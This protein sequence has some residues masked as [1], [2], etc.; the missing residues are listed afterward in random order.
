MF[1]F[2]ALVFAGTFV[3]LGVGSGSAGIGDLL[4]GN[5]DF[6]SQGGGSPSVAKARRKAEANPQDPQAQRAYA[7][8]LQA[9]G[10][11]EEAIPALRRY[12]A[13]RPRNVE[14]LQDLA[15]A[16]SERLTRLQTE[17]QTAQLQA[18][19]VQPPAAVVL[20]S[21]NPL[22]QELSQDKLSGALAAA[23]TQ[24][25]SEA[26]RKVQQAGGDLVSVYG[27]IAS[28]QPADPSWQLQLILAAQNAGDIPT[29]IAA[30]RRFLQLAPDDPSAPQ[31]RARLKQLQQYQAAQQGRSSGGSGG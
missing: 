15:V 12:V 27:R 31:V 5:L 26:Y 23:A 30:S 10:Q 19:D 17:A 22:G 6:L 4:Q 1:A 14:G 20:G 7:Q 24:R 25:A 29:E 21:A 8:A 18:Q 3:F 28:L 16:L 2:L 11:I 13:L 9:D